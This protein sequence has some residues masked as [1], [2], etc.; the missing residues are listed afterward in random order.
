MGWRSSRCYLRRNYHTDLVA[1]E[2]APSSRNSTKYMLYSQA[3]RSWFRN[4]FSYLELQTEFITLN[5]CSSLWL[6]DH[7]FSV[8]VCSL[9]QVQAHIPRR[10]LIDLHNVQGEHT[11]GSKNPIFRVPTPTFS[12][13]QIST[14][15][16]V[17]KIVRK[18]DNFSE[19][20]CPRH[21]LNKNNVTQELIK[22]IDEDEVIALTL[23][24]ST[25]VSF[26]IQDTR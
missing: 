16:V 18:Y 14:P 9:M 12:N 20:G 19:F 13:V 23:Q 2:C 17:R 26:Q 10:N 22:N 8:A 21:I 25:T 6:L 3:S 11:S 5:A 1:D 24:F 15:V 4:A 7:A